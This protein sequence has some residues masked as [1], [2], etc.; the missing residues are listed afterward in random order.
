MATRGSVK[1]GLPD[2]VAA[3]VR[4]QILSGEFRPGMFLRLEP[5][6]EAVGVSNTP[7][8]EGLL[9]LRSEGFVELVPRRGFMVASF[10]PED[11]RDIFW[12]QSKIAGELA[13]RAAKQI[14]PE[15]IAKLEELTA[16]F[17][18]A[19]KA[20]DKDRIA[21]LGSEFHAVINRAAG[22]RRLALILQTVVSQLPS[23]F[24]ATIDGQVAATHSE[25]PQ[26]VEAMKKRSVRT[27]R[28]LMEA[29]IL[30]SADHL[31]ETLNGRGLWDTEQSA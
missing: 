21:D 25:H 5:I 1:Q 14:S 29:H 31:I 13:A 4:E 11:V 7:V 10:S 28:A 15:Q 20:R 12:A 6:A 27:A 19:V 24:Y 9:T 22:S 23:S 18:R 17:K 26:I 2:E 16:E 8:R 3:Y 30:G